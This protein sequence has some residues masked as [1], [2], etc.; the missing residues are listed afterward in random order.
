MRQEL[1]VV[2]DFGGGNNQLIARRIRELSV[3]SEMVPHDISYEELQAKNP[4]ALILSGEPISATPTCDERI[5]S[6]GIPILGIGF[7]M[8]WMASKLGGTVKAAGRYE[9]GRSQLHIKQED[10]LFENVGTELEVWIPDGD[11]IQTLPE[12]FQ[13][14]A[15]TDSC[16]VAAMSDEQRKFYGV[17]FYPEMKDTPVGQKILA[18]FLFQVCKLKGDWNLRDFIDESIEDIR[19]QVGAKKVL[20][21]LSGGVDSSVAATLVHKAVG[22]QLICVY[23]DHGLMRKG[24]SEEIVT[25]FEKKLGINLVFV[26]AKERFLSRLVG[27]RDPEQKRKIIGETFIRVFE[28]EAA[29]LGQID[30][31]VQVPFIPM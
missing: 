20:C 25:T 13:L 15:A 28:E 26:D 3:F 27:I 30:Y 14:T 5:F 29:K 8:Q 1:V 21:A 22:D 18:N 10:K 23:V 2:L 16:A 11:P 4:D 9:Y 19:Q 7:G 31:L 17:Q 24:E 12:G 6:L